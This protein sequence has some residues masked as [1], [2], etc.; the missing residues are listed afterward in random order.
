[1]AVIVGPG[2]AKYL[3]LNQLCLITAYSFVA[4]ITGF[5][6]EEFL[7]GAVEVGL[8]RVVQS[9]RP[10][11]LSVQELQ[12]NLHKLR[13]TRQIGTLLRITLPAQSPMLS[14]VLLSDK[15][16]NGNTCYRH[17]V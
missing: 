14:W 8:L 2:L 6:R 15:V 9:L 16:E 1:M 11:V 17:H 5:P 13:T 4:L 10:R 12:P 3:T 7:Q